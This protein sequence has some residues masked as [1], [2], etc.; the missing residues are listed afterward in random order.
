M[1]CHGK[2]C[3]SIQSIIIAKEN[4]NIFHCTNLEPVACHT[5]GS[6]VT[7]CAMVAA[8]AAAADFCEW[9]AFSLLI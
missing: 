7:G 8:A 5:T 6:T 4:K 3:H 2:T 1:T 9:S